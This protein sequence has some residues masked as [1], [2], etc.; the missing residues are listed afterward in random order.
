MLVSTM[1]AAKTSAMMPK[2]PKASNP[3]PDFFTFAFLPKACTGWVVSLTSWIQ[4]RLRASGK[5]EICDDWTINRVEAAG[6]AGI[7]ALPRQAARM[8]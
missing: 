6:A 4:A 7:A 5:M 3:P 8:R 2:M 1:A